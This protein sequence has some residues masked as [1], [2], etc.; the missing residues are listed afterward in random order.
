MSTT[1]SP[2]HDIVARLRLARVEGV[3]PIAYRRMLQRFRSATAALEA[4][5][6]LLRSGGR[7]SVPEIPSQTQAE[8]ELAR[9]DQIGARLL[10]LDTQG[11]PPLL[12]LLEDAPPVLGVLGDPGV[13][14]Q[15]AVALVGARNASANGQRLA[16]RLAAELAH[17][18]VV[19]SGLARGIDAAAHQGAMATGRTVAAVAGGLD[20]VYPAEHAALQRR[21]AE[22]GAVVA[23]A[24]LGTAPQAR[25]F[26]RR[27]RIIAGL[28]LGVVV[29]EAALRS[30]SLITTRIAQDL[31]REVFAVPGSPLDPRSHGSN[32]LIRQGAVLTESAADVLAHLPDLPAHSLFSQLPQAHA[33]L[34]ES[35]P[36]P[37]APAMNLTNIKEQVI[38]L[39]SPS[40]T[41]VDELVRRCQFSSAAVMAALLELELAGR[42]EALPGNRVALLAR[43]AH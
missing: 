42:V 27:N 6:E 39:L 41:A 31:G 16:E 38:D 10:V 33:G 23:E 30:G 9:L 21:I 24:P 25:H 29:V 35:P 26:P 7:T 36:E 5:P 19:I 8:D 12:S 3:G 18:I 2:L 14:A 28:S 13:L 17:G 11:Y 20:I 15:P 43:K 4:L 32:D 37:L 1:C 34:A 40:P 22:N